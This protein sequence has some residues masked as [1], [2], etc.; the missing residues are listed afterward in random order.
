[1]YIACDWLSDYINHQQSPDTLARILTNTGLEVEGQ[2]TFTDRPPCL[3][4]LVVGHVLTAEA[5]PD[6]D[7]LTVTTV[8]TGAEEPS[9]I[10]CGA[11]NVAAGQKV[12]VAPVG[13]T[14]Q[15][16][17][18]KQL[19]VQKS[20][21]RGVRSYGMIVAEDEIGLSYDHDGILVLEDEARPGQPFTAYRQFPGQETLE[22]SLTPNR[23]DAASHLGVA[24][25]LSAYL[26]I[27]V[28]YPD[29][30]A[31]S[32]DHPGH[33]VDIR[34]AD[35]HQCPRYTGAVITDVTIGSSPDW[36]QHRLKAVGL[37]PINNLVDVTN[38]VMM[39]W[40]HPLH[41]FDY[42]QINGKAL[43][44]V[45]AGKGAAFTTLDGVQRELSGEELMIA[46]EQQN[47]AMAGIIGGQH[48]GIKEDTSAIF[49]ESACFNSTT[50]R[51][52]A[53]YHQLMTDA[54]FRFERGTDP[55]ITPVV[56][57][58]A[59]LLIQQVAGGSISSE[60]MDAYPGQEAPVQLWLSYSYLY[61]LL[62]DHI[63]ADRVQRI[64]VRLG[65]TVDEATDNGLLVTVPTFRTDVTRPVDVVEEVVR[66]YSLDA[67]GSES[68]PT[69]RLAQQFDHSDE[70]LKQR[71]SRY[72]TAQGFY[73][74]VTPPFTSQETEAELLNG[75]GPQPVPVV[76]PLNQAQDGLRTTPLLNGLEA[77]SYNL[78][79]KQ[80]NLRLFELA[81]TYQQNGNST[82]EQD[83]LSLLLTG[84]YHEPTWYQAAAEVDLYYLKGI[85]H[86]LLQASGVM[87]WE[88]SE[89]QNA[90]LSDGLLLSVE[91]KQLASL[92]SVSPGILKA[93][94]IKQPVLHARL[95]LELLRAL[96]Q[97]NAP[98]FRPISKFP[99]IERDI[100]VLVPADLSYQVVKDTIEAAG[101]PELIDFRLFDVYQGEHVPEATKSLALRLTLQDAE[102]TMEDERIDAVVDQLLSALQKGAKAQIRG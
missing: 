23:G 85:V 94:D 87:N 34:I 72:L 45:Q 100:A 17:N 21:I 7:N 36:L 99:Q 31:F 14:I 43:N 96:Y 16:I 47:L 68:T 92:G 61:R 73:E 28:Q 41:A 88:A 29:T 11:P 19:T 38:Y 63:P 78:R 4:S 95:D 25:D 84:R 76:N 54:S 30:S 102:K 91:G 64:L 2:Y 97:G 75:A 89:I 8:D 86:N 51:K 27:P 69:V 70:H 42:E 59:A 46:D 37:Q 57:R 13:A 26:D 71:L 66:I 15:H 22:I 93:Y 12:V 62:G 60:V 98:F 55:E 39:E 20:K 77:I 53:T 81:R 50:I 10:I 35:Q 24:R 9:Q 79:R 3:E 40:G 44:I 52:A 74:M 80:Q 1:M 32:I 18:G 49:L 82:A 6:A 58:R 90:E 67:L 101:I 65:F 56:L 48:S 33:P 83:V 5:H